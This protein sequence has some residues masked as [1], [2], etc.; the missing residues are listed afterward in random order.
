FDPAVADAFCR[1]APELLDGF[2]GA[3]LWES[4]MAAEPGEPAML[5][6]EQVDEGLRVIGDFA[7]MTIPYTLGH[8]AAVAELAAAAGEQT[9]LDAEAC[10]TCAERASCTTWGGSR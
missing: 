8:S 9:G 4:A 5:E 7:D 10:L 3:G 1:A 2:D 6:G